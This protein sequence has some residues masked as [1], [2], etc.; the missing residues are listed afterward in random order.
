MFCFGVQVLES[1]SGLGSAPSVRRGGART[2][3]NSAEP[4]AFGVG[5]RAVARGSRVFFVEVRRREGQGG[6][7]PAYGSSAG[8]G[9]LRLGLVSPNSRRGVSGCRPLPCVTGSRAREPDADTTIDATNAEPLPSG[10]ND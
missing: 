10:G 8:L 9:A 2:R 4:G 1:G 6:A 5:A 3:P 7:T